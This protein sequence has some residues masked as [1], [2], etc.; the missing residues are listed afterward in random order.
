MICQVY[1]P[2]KN[3]W[4]SLPVPN[5]FRAEFSVVSNHEQ[6]FVVPKYWEDVHPEKVEVYDPNQNTWMSLPDLPFQ[7]RSPKAVVLEDK[8]IVYENNEE[9]S[10]RYQDVDPPV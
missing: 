5:I 1:N 7:Y 2:E 3:T 10:R 6:V 9:Q 8:I 4:I